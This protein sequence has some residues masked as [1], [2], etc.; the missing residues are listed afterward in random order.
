MVSEFPSG[1][2]SPNAELLHSVGG[3]VPAGVYE[4]TVGAEGFGGVG[5]LRSEFGVFD[6]LREEYFWQPF[7]RYFTHTRNFEHEFAVWMS[8]VE[9]TLNPN[10]ET[11]QVDD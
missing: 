7:A 6:V 9:H 1:E 10:S 11:E 2:T 3:V 4:W 8:E 5:G